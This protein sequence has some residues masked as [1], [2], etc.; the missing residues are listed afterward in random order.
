MFRHMRDGS[1][2]PDLSEIFRVEAVAD[3]SARP[4]GDEPVV[5]EREM[6]AGDE[7]DASD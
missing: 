3:S 7:L 1:Y 6:E 2:D 4:E 5:A